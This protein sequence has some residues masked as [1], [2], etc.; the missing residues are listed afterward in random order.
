[1]P[2]IMINEA[3]WIERGDGAAV[4]H[5]VIRL[6]KP[7]RGVSFGTRRTL[8]DVALLDS[9][10]RASAPVAE[11]AD[12][13]P[14]TA[15]EEAEYDRLDAKLAG[16]IGDARTLRRFNALRLRSLTYGSQVAA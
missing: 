5:R 1:M 9:G 6:G 8:I 10:G 4:A 14:L 11:L 7:F 16:T 15:A 12:A 3:L 13:R 2:D